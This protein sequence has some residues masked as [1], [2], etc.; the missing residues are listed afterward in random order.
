MNFVEEINLK[1]LFDYFISK[2]SVIILITLI[3][4]VVGCSYALFF[5]KPL[6]KSSTTLVLTRTD[7]ENSNTITQNDITLNQKLLSTY[8]EIVKSRRVINQV[9]T[10]LSLDTTFEV[11]NKNISVTSVQD[12]ELI[13]IIVSDENP[14]M[15]K[16]IADETAKVFSSEIQE[17]YQIKNISIVDTAVVANSPYNINITKQLII[18][19]FIGVVLG[20]GVVFV[21]YYF[22]TSIKNVEEVE[23][24]LELPILGQIPMKQKRRKK[25]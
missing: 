18:Y 8:R 1:E 9:I 3:I 14:E 19:L 25:A 13:K 23:S 16:K 20:L 17:M 7:T 6:Y 11:L 10:D 12:T 5:Q 15:A 22:D 4:A 24:K 2:I 21:I